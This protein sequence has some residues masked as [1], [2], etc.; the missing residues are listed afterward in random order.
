M[1]WTL[2]FERQIKK[3][4]EIEKYI[5]KETKKKYEASEYKNRFPESLKVKPLCC[6]IYGYHLELFWYISW[7]FPTGL[8]KVNIISL[9]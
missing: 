4:R 9:G 2:F 5:L 6:I 7:V 8:S 1:N 3:G